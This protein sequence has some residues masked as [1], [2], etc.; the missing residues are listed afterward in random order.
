MNCCVSE[1]EKDN[2]S[3]FILLS[4]YIMARVSTFHV[5]VAIENIFHLRITV[6]LTVPGLVQIQAHSGY[7]DPA[8]VGTDL[9]CKDLCSLK[10]NS[11]TKYCIQHN[12]G[13]ILNITYHSHYIIVRNPAYSYFT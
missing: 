5:V 2:C 12:N 6:E 1:C 7:V 3:S 11:Y 8:V 10:D 13:V 9:P 4:L